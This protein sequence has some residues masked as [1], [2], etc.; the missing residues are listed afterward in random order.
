MEKKFRQTVFE[1]R[2]FNPSK[3]FTSFDYTELN[4]EDIVIG[5][6]NEG[7]ILKVDGIYYIYGGEKYNECNEERLSI[8]R[9]KHGKKIIKEISI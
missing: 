2:Q 6:C 5:Y 7:E 3:R 1:F 4:W 9:F 8:I